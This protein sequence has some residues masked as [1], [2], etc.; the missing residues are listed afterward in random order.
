MSLV[1]P[2]ELVVEPCSSA[3]ASVSEHSDYLAAAELLVVE[4]A[5]ADT[6]LAE[7][8][9]AAASVVAAPELVGKSTGTAA[10]RPA[11]EW[12]L[13]AADTQAER[14]GTAAAPVV[15][16]RSTVAAAVDIAALDTG[17]PADSDSRKV[18]AVVGIA[19]PVVASFA[20]E[21]PG[22]ASGTAGRNSFRSSTTSSH[23]RQSIG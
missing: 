5:A 21:L 11:D 4:Q 8:L 13:E 14:S 20:A 22:S 15:E 9:A 10:E 16:G 17:R 6:G 18:L 12:Q 1:E 23:R 19:D 2:V 3:E 7:R